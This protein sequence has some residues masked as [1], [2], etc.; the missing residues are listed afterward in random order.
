MRLLHG[1]GASVLGHSMSY[2]GHCSATVYLKGALNCGRW[3]RYFPD[4]VGE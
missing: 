4:E 1:S 2:S 3:R